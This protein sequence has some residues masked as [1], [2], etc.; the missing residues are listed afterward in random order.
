MKILLT[1]DGYAPM[2]NGVVTSVM[3]LQRVLT[4]RGHEVRVL[5]LSNDEHSSFKEGVYYLA[6]FRIPIYR[7]LH[8][9]LHIPQVFMQDILSWK[10]DIVHSQC[11][12]FTFGFARRIAQRSNVPLVHTYHT[13]YES[14]ARYVKLNERMGDMAVPHFLQRRLRNLQM[15]IA[16]TQKVADA[17]KSYRLTS[18][19]SIVP[20]GIDLSKF[21]L[22][23]SRE[24]LEKR[25]ASLGLN[26]DSVI[27]LSVGRIAQE[28]NPEELLKNMVPL[29][30]DFPKLVL[31]FIGDGPQ[32]EYL[33]DRIRTL[34]L[35]G[36]VFFSG[37]VNP[38]EIA[39][40]YQL[41]TIFVSASDSETQGL[42]YIEAMASGLPVICRYDS[43]LKNV[44]KEG[45]DGFTYTKAS[46]YVSAITHT[47]TDKEL[48]ESLSSQARILAKEY[49]IERFGEEI[50]RI[51]LQCIDTYKA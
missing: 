10:P 20:T 12:F 2:I 42:T 49:S 45:I 40:Y 9:T 27:L 44:I 35:S 25:K 24:N 28:K 21:T 13:M 4:N 23:E 38:T 18:P 31:L 14:Y 34:N 19:I 37:M 17:L 39:S 47:L 33:A 50:E 5:T 43:C 3:N 30:Q 15:I 11:E 22:R 29:V 51:Y 8:A 26:P 16:P 48:Y 1:T 36:R 41:G 32:R 46:E 7:D 6:S